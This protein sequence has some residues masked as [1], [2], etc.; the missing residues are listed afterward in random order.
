MNTKQ[1]EMKFKKM[2]HPDIKNYLD[3]VLLDW[4]N[5]AHSGDVI[6]M[7]DFEDIYRCSSSMFQS[8]QWYLN[9]P[10]DNHQQAKKSK[11]AYDRGLSLIDSNT[12]SRHLEDYVDDSDEL[13]Q[14]LYQLRKKYR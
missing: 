7:D 11:N 13:V 9:N 5:E 12:G 6:F 14:V 10:K 3:F 2:L 8:L 1:L 4:N